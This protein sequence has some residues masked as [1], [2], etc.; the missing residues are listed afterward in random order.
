M[1]SR[2]AKKSAAAAVTTA[3]RLHWQVARRSDYDVVKAIAL[4]QVLD[5]VYCID[6]V[7]LYTDFF[8]YL[9]RIGLWD[10]IA[11][12]TPENKERFII[13]TLPYVLIYMQKQIAGL[14]SINAVEDVLLTEEAAMRTVGFNA[15]QIKE[16][17]SRRGRQRRNEGG[18]PGKPVAADSLSQNFCEIA[19]PAIEA[20]FNTAVRA[21][22]AQG[23]FPRQVTLALDPTDVETSA[24]FGGAG[25]VTRKKKIR[26]KRHRLTTVAVTVYGFRLIVVMETTTRIPVAAKLV[27]IQANGIK[28]WKEMVAQARTNLVGHAEITTVVADREFVDGEI[29]WWVRQEGLGFVIPGK[30]NMDV[31][32]EARQRMRQARAGTFMDGATR[33][34]RNVQVKRGQGREQHIET[35]TTIVWGIEGLVG[36]DTYGPEEEMQKETPQGHAQS[37]AQHRRRGQV[38]QQAGTPG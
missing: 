11:A 37:C 29:M 13:G 20:L 19:A 22:A 6:Y 34:E 30:S 38:E 12:L 8:E 32:R 23:V 17:I 3:C 4:Q 1:S 33:H 18:A 9:R 5:A 24:R 14:P 16:G 31:T 35:Q 25:H 2:S 26:D 21:L 10:A 27:Q 7:S 28:Y 15:H 36:L